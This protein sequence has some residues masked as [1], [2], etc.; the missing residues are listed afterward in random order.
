MNVTTDD[1]FLI[2]GMKEVEMY[3]LRKQLADRHAV[4]TPKDTLEPKAPKGNP[5]CPPSS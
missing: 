5:P 4:P 2:I 1:L 3:L